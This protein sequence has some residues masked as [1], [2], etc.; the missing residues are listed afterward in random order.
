MKRFLSLLIIAVIGGIAIFGIMPGC[1]EL[2][3]NEYYDTIADTFTLL[4]SSCVEYCHSDQN[5]DMEIAIAQYENSPHA[6]ANLSDDT[7]LGT[8]ANVCGPECH[9]K[10]GFIRSLNNLSGT[11]DIPTNIDCFTCHQPHTAPFDFSLRDTT[12]VVLV[13]GVTTYNK[14]ESNMC[15]RCHQSFDNTLANITDN[16]IIGATWDQFINHAW[17]DAEML[18]ATGGYEYAAVTYEHSGHA[19]AAKGCVTCHQ[20]QASGFLL[21][22]H[23]LNI[24]DPFNDNSFNVETCN[25]ADCHST[26]PLTTLAVNARQTL[27]QQKLDSLEAQL[28]ADSLLLVFGEQIIPNIDMIIQ[29][30]DSVGALYNYYFIKNDKSRGIHDFVYDTLLIESS[31]KY[32]RGDYTP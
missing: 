17:S 26:A 10:E 9:S 27:V 15:V 6:L 21:G 31:I 7:T 12:E 18:S 11:I 16:L 30:A 5:T 8:S 22:G 28:V 24:R 23:S 25:R 14:K 20:E 4:D 13:D 19:D 32:L 1:D 2:V 29:T 3:T